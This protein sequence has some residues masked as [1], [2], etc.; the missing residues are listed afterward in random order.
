MKRSPP[1]SGPGAPPAPPAG[2]DPTRAAERG[3]P[4]PR[5]FAFW[6][7][8][9]YG[10][11]WVSFL[12]V[13]G[14]ARWLRPDRAGLG[15]HTELGLPPC[16]FYEAFHKPCPS[17]GMTTSFAWMLHGH[18]IT[19]IQTQPAGVGV[20]LATLCAWFYLPVAWKKR[21]PFE[22]LFDLPAFLPTVVA[23][24]VLILV[25]WVWRLLT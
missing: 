23:L 5:P 1:A 10:F 12:A 8:I 14:V 20:F 19:A 18:P 24:I 7:H 2:P 21:R 11:C 22:H 15:T 16:G 13:L 25:V 4:K 6:D 17:C 9:L 3:A